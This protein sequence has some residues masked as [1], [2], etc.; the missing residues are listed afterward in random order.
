MTKSGKMAVSDRGESRSE[1]IARRIFML[2]AFF[3]FVSVC[4][5]VAMWLCARAIPTIGVLLL[6]V[7]AIPEDAQLVVWVYGY[8]MPYAVASALV[9][10]ASVI[11]L[12]HVFGSLTSL[13]R[14]LAAR[15]GRWYDGKRGAK[16]A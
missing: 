6:E 10:V 12:R 8:I 2:A 14:L 11:C 5:V 3:L 16:A 9:V 7:A 15:L 1:T 4:L 13:A